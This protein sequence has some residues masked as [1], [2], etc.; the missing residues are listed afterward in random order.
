VVGRVDTEA[1]G[2]RLVD[3]GDG[4]LRTANL[5]LQL[6]DQVVLWRVASMRRNVWND[7]LSRREGFPRSARRNEEEDRV[8]RVVVSEFV[9]LGDDGVAILTYEPAARAGQ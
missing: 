7:K 3:R 6:L 1:L 8:G 4:D 5:T 2:D 9:S